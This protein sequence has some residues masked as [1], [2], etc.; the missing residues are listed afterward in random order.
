MVEVC[1]AP[2][3]TERM[4]EARSAAV[5]CSS[6]ARSR[7]HD[8]RSF[9]IPSL[10]SLKWLGE[11][12]PT[13]LSGQSR[14]YSRSFANRSLTVDPSILCARRIELLR[15]AMRGAISLYAYTYAGWKGGTEYIR[16]LT[17]GLRNSGIKLM[18]CPRMNTS[19]VYFI[20]KSRY[21]WSL[22]LRTHSES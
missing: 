22:P 16:E 17:D 9:Y 2:E 7:S 1:I 10:N 14:P 15:V 5:R 20:A 4:R 19:T 11:N 13:A 18:N 3:F 8:M 6:F 12:Q 21:S